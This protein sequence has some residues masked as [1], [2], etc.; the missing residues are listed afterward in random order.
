MPS[1]TQNGRDPLLDSRI[2][3]VDVAQLLGD[4]QRLLAIS[5]GGAVKSCRD[6][7][8][9]IRCRRVGSRGAFLPPFSNSGS[10][11]PLRRIPV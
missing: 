3:P 9:S 6:R 7:Y 1:R 8:N 11:G 5:D 2:L 10:A 4:E